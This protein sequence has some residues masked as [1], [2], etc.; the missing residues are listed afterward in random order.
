MERIVEV[1]LNATIESCF[2]LVVRILDTLT[3]NLDQS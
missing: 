2:R 1:S 3:F